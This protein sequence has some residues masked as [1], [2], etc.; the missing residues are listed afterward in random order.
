MI[1]ELLAWLIDATL[2][3]SLACIA[4]A[5]LRK[6]LRRML[7]AEI[8]CRIW[9]AVPLAALGACFTLPQ[10]VVLNAAAQTPSLVGGAPLAWAVHIRSAVSRI[11]ADRWLLVA[12]L[13][14]AVVF[15]FVFAWRQR[16]HVA[17]LRMRREADGVWRSAT[18]GAAPAVLG[19]WRQ[20]LVLPAGFE[21]DYSAEE[22]ELVIAHERMHQRRGDPLALAVCALLRVLFWFNPIVHAAGALF[23][24]DV[25]L[26]CDAAVLRI[27]PH[28]RRV[29]AEALFKTGLG[30]GTPPLGC[31]W[32][33]VPPI[34]ERIMML[35]QK[36]PARG[37]RIVGAVVVAL[38][39]SGAVGLAMAGHEPARQAAGTFAAQADGRS[40]FYRIDLTMYENG[41]P[42]AHPVVIAR[43]GDLATVK[44]GEGVNAW[45]MRFKVSPA[46]GSHAGATQI[47]G[48][49]LGADADRVIGHVNVAITAGAPAAIALDDR[50]MRRAYRVEARV[51][52]APPPPPPPAPSMPSMAGIAPP[53]PPSPPAPPPW[54]AAAPGS[55]HV[56]VS[57][58]HADG[59]RWP[60][61]PPPP[62]MQPAPPL[63]PAPL[64]ASMPPAASVSPAPPVGQ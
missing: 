35:K 15:A 51:N 33:P 31:P 30:E 24:R 18:R 46:A 43:A 23:R 48:D 27:R 55:P 21:S 7:G 9:V 37:A 22:R 20:R 44:I 60:A 58:Q 5:V 54:P 40:P 12:W 36:S 59:G 52:I 32:Y 57:V 49:V 8:A 6:P 19:V 28:S 63:P 14:G 62:P 64:D 11:A 13:M 38:A 4:I 1:A 61:S 41:R 10:R 45:G 25:E 56:M 26:A 50:A 2:A 16:R 42:V 53:P 17:S 29:Y 34:K 47:S 39:A 3:T